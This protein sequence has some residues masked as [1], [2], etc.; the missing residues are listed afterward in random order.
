LSHQIHDPYDW[1]D[2]D[3]GISRYRSAFAPIAALADPGRIAMTSPE[4]QELLRALDEM[5]D[6]FPD[7]RLGQMIAN[8]AVV[9]RGATAE[10]IWDVEDHE[11]LAAIHRHLQR[12][13]V[14]SSSNR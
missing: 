6:T 14:T 11:L 8:L 1:W 12:R 3:P 13:G 5:S 4:R 9:A 10:A 7:C 2:G